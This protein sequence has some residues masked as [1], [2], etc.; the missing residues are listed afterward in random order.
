MAKYL[1]MFMSSDEQWAG[2]PEAERNAKYAEIGKWWEDHSKAGRIIGGVELAPRTTATTVRHTPKGAV[3]TDGP[4]MEAKEL[5]G[6]Y[7]VIE[8]PSLDEAIAM[9]KTWP[10]GSTIEIR[11]LAQ[12]P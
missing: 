3:V 4:Y 2:M 12:M 10:A 11:P 6:G 1:L 7:G 5:I 9:A 8:V